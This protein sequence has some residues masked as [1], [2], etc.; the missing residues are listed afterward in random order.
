MLWA[1]VHDRPGPV[2]LLA[3]AA[4]GGLRTAVDEDLLRVVG[5]AEAVRIVVVV[6]NAEI[7]VIVA[8]RIAPLIGRV[9]PAGVEA[10][11]VGLV[12]VAAVL[13]VQVARQRRT[14]GAA[15]DDAGNRRRAAAIAARR[16][17]EARRSARPRSRPRGQ[18]RSGTPDRNCRRCRCRC[19]CSVGATA[20]SAD[21]CRNH[22]RCHSHSHRSN[23]NRRSG[24]CRAR[25]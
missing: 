1:L 9:R 2:R 13:A 10:V 22:C 24:D 3:G 16:C 8:A 20:H 12:G 5:A 14:D 4:A 15:D 19:A 21:R 17:R 18:P 6:G 23:R 11:I 7:A 25:R